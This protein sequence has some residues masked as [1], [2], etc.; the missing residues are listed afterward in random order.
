MQLLTARKQDFTVKAGNPAANSLL[1]N[2]GA[3]ILATSFKKIF[4]MVQNNA[5]LL[6]KISVNSLSRYTAVFNK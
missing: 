2:T 3:C 1:T 5:S 6:F 4:L